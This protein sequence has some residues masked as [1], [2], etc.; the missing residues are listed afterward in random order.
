MP[1]VWEERLVE[2]T[3]GQGRRRSGMVAWQGERR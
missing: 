2:L 3:I 1:G